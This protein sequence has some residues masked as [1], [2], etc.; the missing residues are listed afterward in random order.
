MI[1]CYAILYKKYN[2]KLLL[3]LNTCMEENK[4]KNEYVREYY[5]QH[6]KEYDTYTDERWHSSVTGEFDYLQTSRSIEKALDGQEYK[7][8]LEIGPGDGVWTRQIKQHVKGPMYLIEQSD[9]ML[10]IAKRRLS[11]IKDM[12]FERSDFMESNAPG[13]N[14]LIIA[15]RCF[16]YFTNKNEGLKKMCNLLSVGGKLV[17]VTKN[18]DLYTTVNVQKRVVHSDQVTKTQMSDLL[19]QNGFIVN[20]IFP[21]TLRWKVKYRVMR[22]IFDALHRVAVWSRGRL[23]IPVL[24]KYATESYVYVATKL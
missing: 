1:I 9:E 12:S 2:K 6:V 19:S 5:N 24:Y 11:G 16:E 23:F 22:Y 8:V 13:E 17:I 18:A 7:K 10:N 14:D 3:L 15:V 21:A 20:Y 4:L